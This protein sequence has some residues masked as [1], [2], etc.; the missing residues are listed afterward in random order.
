[1][2]IWEP[3]GGPRLVAAIVIFYAVGTMGS[4]YLLRTGRFRIWTRLLL[5]LYSVGDVWCVIVLA[6]TMKNNI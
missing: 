6:L 4:A 5:L 1:M 3:D 2:E